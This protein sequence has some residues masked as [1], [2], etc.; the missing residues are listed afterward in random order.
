M[1]KWND[2]RYFE[3]FRIRGEVNYFIEKSVQKPD[4]DNTYVDEITPWLD[5]W[6]GGG[7]DVVDDTSWH[8]RLI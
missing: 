1:I 3:H 2:Q 8:N 7:H 5:G 6:G 4:D